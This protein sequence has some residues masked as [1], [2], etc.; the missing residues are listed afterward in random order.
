MTDAIKNA[1]IYVKVFYFVFI[2]F[3][4]ALKW[5]KVLLSEYTIIKR[6]KTYSDSMISNAVLK[7]VIGW[8]LCPCFFLKYIKGHDSD[9]EYTN[10]DELS[11]YGNI[12]W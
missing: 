12:W 11:M 6:S 8:P 2:I 4:H 5:A 10:M 9:A 1:D 7:N 3:H